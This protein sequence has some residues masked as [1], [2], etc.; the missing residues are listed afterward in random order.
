[1]PLTSLTL[2]N[3]LLRRMA[4]L[5]A[6]DQKTVKEFMVQTLTYEVARFE[7]C[8]RVA[9]ELDKSDPASL[10]RGIRRALP[11]PAS[12]LTLTADDATEPP[13]CARGRRPFRARS[14]RRHSHRCKR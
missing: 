11:A 5:A 3:D 1:M 13:N 8:E 7:W 9:A 10:V 14:A 4:R 6:Q 2:P 12:G